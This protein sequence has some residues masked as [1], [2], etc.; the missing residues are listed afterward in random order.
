MRQSVLLIFLIILSCNPKKNQVGSA[1]HFLP[2]NPDLILKINHPVA[3]QSEIKNNHFLQKIKTTSFLETLRNKLKWVAL[4]KVGSNSIIGLYPLGRNNHEFVLLKTSDSIPLHMESTSERKTDTLIYENQEIIKYQIENESFYKT[5]L[6]NKMLLSSSQLLLENTIRS[7]GQH[8]VSTVLEKLF[9]TSDISKPASIFLNLKSSNLFSPELQQPKQIGFGIFANWIAVDFEAKQDELLL[10]GVAV[11]N[12]SISQFINL[13][14]ETRPLLDR[15]ASIAPQNA[16]AILSFTFDDFN[17][18]KG[19]QRTF[20]DLAS[21]TND[22][23]N[24]I[25]EVGVI[26]LHDKNV[27]AIHAF[28][29]ASFINAIENLK[30]TRSDYQ[31]VDIWRLNTSDFANSLFQPLV[32]NNKWKFYAVLENT[33]VFSEE[34]NAIKTIIASKRNGVTFEKGAIYQ[35]IKAQLGTESSVFFVSGTKGLETFLNRH[36]TSSIA[37][38]FAALNLKDIGFATQLT[39]DDDFAHFNI[40]ITEIQNTPTNTSVAPIYNLELDSDLVINPQFVKNHRNNTY[41][42]VVQDQDYNLYLISTEGKVLWKKHLEGTIR[43]KIHQVDLFKNGKLQLAFCTNNQF[44]ILD[45]NGEEVVPFNKKYEGGNLN[46]LAVFDYENT[47]NYRFVVTQG[48]KVF[49]YNSKGKVVDGFTYTDAESPIIDA[50][51]HFR[52]SGKDYLVFQLENG[53]LKIKHRAGGDRVKVNRTI[54]FSNNEVFFYR[55]KFSV[56]DKKGVL[57]QVDT[58]GKLSATNFNLTE[59]HGMFA[60]SKSLALM[61]DNVLNIK[62][63]KV[64]LEFGVYSQPKIFYIDDKIYV[65]VTDLQNQ[66]IYLFDSQAKTIPNFPVYGS[67]VIDLL[68]MDNDNKLELV[69]KDQENSIIVYTIN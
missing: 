4:D 27:L 53:M 9:Q 64:E 13:F 36:F 20:L 1:L 18:F 46:P 31:G 7:N 30:T 8:A 25:E 39:A 11:A 37:N 62:G 32:K 3:F 40:L 15:T 14:D 50:P 12:D 42:I 33:H 59:N 52:I 23:I 68:D 43:G 24:N 5:R 45:R 17:Q 65:T 28:E 47:R 57:H 21:V 48:R 63:K 29:N 41:E 35:S 58:K 10:S 66:K 44:L 55:N 26:F 69:S 49:M 19:N 2:P 51:K 67:S 60:T 16:E 61:D 56:T 34:E 54:S 38:E 6:G 22:S